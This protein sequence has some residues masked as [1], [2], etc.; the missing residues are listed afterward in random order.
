MKNTEIEN[1]ISAAFE[2]LMPKDAFEKISAK[3]TP[4]PISNE[5]TEIKMTV[6]RNNLSRFSP[7]AAAA[8]F[9]LI[10]GIFGAAYYNA[11]F[12]PD[13][14]IDIDVNPSIELVTN[15][16]D[17]VLKAQAVNQDGEEILDGMD[18][19][20][21]S[22]KVAVNAIV[23]SMVQKGYVVDENSSI[24]VTVANNDEVK[25]KKIKNEIVS[26]IDL[27][28]NELKVD[29]P[30]INQSVGKA[31]DAEKFAKEN[32]IS[33]GKAVFVLN[34]AEKDSSLDAK[35]LAKK[36]IKE[37][38]DIVNEKKIDISDIADYDFDDSIWENIKDSIEDVNKNDNQGVNSKPVSSDDNIISKEK[39]QDIALKH[40]GL[41]KADK[42]LV[43]YDK[44]DNKYDVE[45]KS[46]GFEY[47]YEI[48][49]KSGKVL[50]FDK[51]LDEEAKAP[52]SST[53]SN[54]NLISAAKAKDIALKHA[55]VQK[56]DFLRAELDR[57]GK[58]KK[59][60]IE[61]RANSFEYDYEIN[62][63]SGKVLSFDKERIDDDD[64]E[65]V[66]A[67]VIEQTPLISPQKAK[68]VALKHA[69]VVGA[70]FI[71]AELDE[72]DGLYVYNVEFI[73]ENIDYEYEINAVSGKII[74]F[75]K[76]I[77]D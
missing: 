35:I 74:S 77:D 17:F 52:V 12:A 33:L 40:A 59:F 26:S 44:E 67:P 3:I 24:L 8:V 16:K 73:F 23:G 11:N 10:V 57:D 38:A 45:F 55:D 51:E 32:N 15:K 9:V 25:A 72:D 14:I 18:L 37:L 13:S 34:L 27:S 22:L 28:L 63:E 75:E 64:K 31:D 69:G 36:N 65:E 39:A 54:I 47:D 76:E 56:A 7:V 62:A 49:A 43:E 53:S 60:E 66:K 48:S 30:I 50:S 61:F 2:S 71:K 5:R 6:K 70:S 21:S 41:K 19:K 1:K 68:Q 4:A 58:V 46:N 42:I 20:N 29:A